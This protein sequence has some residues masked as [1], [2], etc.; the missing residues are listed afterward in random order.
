MSFHADLEV[1]ILGVLDVSGCAHGYAIADHIRRASEAAGA[2]IRPSAAQL[3]PVLHRLERDG[4]IEARWVLQKTASRPPRHVY[5][6]TEQGRR[7]LEDGR[8]DWARFAA[9]V[10]LLIDRRQGGDPSPR[11]EA[12]D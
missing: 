10:S 8:A 5:E 9:S 11:G 7:E 6:L 2:R 1:L 12:G 3:Y 4:L